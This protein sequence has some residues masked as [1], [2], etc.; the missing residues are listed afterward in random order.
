MSKQRKLVVTTFYSK[1]KAIWRAERPFKMS[2]EELTE[3]VE[4]LK[5]MDYGTVDACTDD[6]GRMVTFDQNGEFL[7]EVED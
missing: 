5:G 4:R 7:R 3:T 6:T 1:G 2:D